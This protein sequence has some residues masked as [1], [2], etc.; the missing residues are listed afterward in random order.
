MRPG[1]PRP[2]RDSSSPGHEPLTILLLALLLAWLASVI[3][4]TPARGAP[5]AYDDAGGDDVVVTTG[6][7]LSSG[8]A[9][10]LAFASD[11]TAF[12]V[13]ERVEDATTASLSVYRSTDAGRSWSLW[14]TIGGSAGT[15]CE[16][17]ALRVAE[18]TQDRV[19]L[20]YRLSAGGGIGAIM[21]AWSPL[22]ASASWTAAAALAS[23]SVDFTDPSLESD[24]VTQAS[25]VLHLVAT[26]QDADGKDI[27]YT[28]SATY[29]AGW[30]AGY[31][32]GD[33]PL[34]ARNYW[35]PEVK[36]GWGGYVHCVFAFST[37]DGSADWAVRYR[38]AP[39]RGA[40]GAT[41]WGP[42]VYMTSSGDGRN[43]VH[44]TVAAAWG[45]MW[46]VVGWQ[47]QRSDGLVM[48]TG[49]K[50]SSNAGEEWL[51]GYED[52]IPSVHAFG[53]KALPGIDGWIGAGQSTTGDFGVMRASNG[54]PHLWSAFQSFA[55][56]SYAD[57]YAGP[58]T[59]FFDFDPA[60]E[61]RIGMVW[62]RVDAGA[63]GD[64]L[65]FDAE[66][67]R[68]PGWPNLEHGM[69]VALPAV[70]YSAPGITELDGDGASEIVF[71]DAA[72]NVWALNHDGSVVAGWPRSVGSLSAGSE[73]AAGDLDGDGRNE[74]VAGSATGWV[75]AWRHDGTP[76]TGWPVHAGATAQAHV[77]IGALI[78]GS[79]RQVAVTC[80][81]RQTLLRF[82]GTPAP[83][84]PALKG[85]AY[86]AP[87]AIG[88]VDGDGTREVVSLFGAYMNVHDGAGNLRWYRNLLAAG[89]TFSAAPTLA[90]LDL[91]GD[92]EIAAPTDQGDVYVFHHDG[93]DMA[94]WPWSDGTAYPI[95]DLAAANILGGGQP[96]LALT[97]RDA[98]APHSVLLQ[99]TGSTSA[100]WP[101]PAGAGW[102]ESPPIM[103]STSGPPYYWMTLAGSRDGSGYAWT[104]LGVEVPGWPRA[105]GGRATVAPASG[106]L[107]GDGLLEVA[108]LTE[109]PSQLVVLDLGAPVY[110]PTWM[111]RSWWPMVGYNPE[112]QSCLACG[113][114]AVV[115][116]PSADPALPRTAR[117]DPPAPNPARGAVT[118][119]FALPA[120]AAARLVIH[121]VQGRRVREVL[122]R[123]LPAGT[124]EAAWD[125]RDAGGAPAAAGVYFVRLQVAG[126]E[127]E[128]LLTRRLVRLP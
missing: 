54:H 52:S 50:A 31:R 86:T 10:P 11:G 8:V 46:T 42:Y 15:R 41:S 101:R 3:L 24:A 93:T 53:I 94:G 4:V 116:V 108:Y 66:W 107:D 32:I 16:D 104:N 79:P 17:P 38:R 33:M 128:R 88:D 47:K 26:G 73:V 48:G 58:C 64:T 76:L 96:E 97:V 49:L 13:A 92:L 114:D 98:A 74:V 44:P 84:W 63:G 59:Q 29:G 75:Y 39:N 23:A 103:E 109:S 65:F 9:Y 91:D 25:Y 106:D 51:P 100:G 124:H 61:D 27:W 83:G 89:K 68:D 36:A 90:D 20:A 99:Y 123:E 85:V 40:D 95:T 37:E 14:G 19:Y 62:P 69:P 70:P 118:L 110:R 1:H 2:H 87:A 112:R 80:G 45:N 18:G 56:R 125:G 82:D 78:A 127:G 72:A 6:T 113:T 57:A 22:G 119:R 105:L 67:R 81:T 34:A 5:D 102:F 12:A 111:P 21:V 117:L 122:R 55:D 35:L 60:H 7:T 126:P 77:S 120:A 28:R 115:S 121:D 71:S 30:E 43:E